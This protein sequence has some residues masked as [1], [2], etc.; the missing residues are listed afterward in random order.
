MLHRVFVVLMFSL[1]ARPGYSQTPSAVQLQ[2]RVTDDTGGALPGV[3]VETRQNA[4]TSVRTTTT[5]AGGGYIFSGLPS[6]RYDV[7]FAL[8][9][10]GAA[11]K[12]GI[13]VRAD[14]ATSVDAV[15][16]LAMTAD[17]TV[18]G[19]ASFSNLADLANPAENLVGVALA[20]SQGAI[21]AAQLENRAIMRAGE[22]LETVP[23]LIISQHSG[24]GKANQY[25]LR[26]FNLDHGTDFATSVAGVPVNMPTHA[27][28]QGYSDLNFL[29]PELVGSVQ[30]SKGPYYADQGDFSAAGSATINYTNALAQ[31]IVSVGTGQQGWDR[32]LVAVSPTI[33]RGHLLT[34]FEGNHNDGPWVHGDHYQRLNG[35]LRYSEGDAQN[36]FAV[37][38]I[39]YHGRWNSTDQVPQR[40]VDSGLI[41]RYGSIDPT[42]GAETYR[43]SLSADL[44]RSSGNAVN[45]A[46]AYVMAYGLDL[47]SDFTYFLDDP[48][49]GDQFE[50]KDARIVSG[51]RLSHRQLTKWGDHTVDSTFGVQLRHDAIGTVGLFKTEARRQLSTVRDDSVGQTSG[52]VYAQSEIQM[53]AKLRTQAG[54]RADI[55]HFRVNSS[56]PANSGTE[57]QGIVSPKGGLVIGPWAGTEFYANAA[58]GFHSNDARGA[59]ITEDPVTLKPADR[60]TPLVR[61]TGAEIGMRT[62]AIPHVQTTVTAWTLDLASELVFAGDAGTTQAGRPS[63]RVGLEWANYVSP[64]RWLT[65]D[66]DLAFSNARFTDVDPVG[67]HIPGAAGAIISAGASVQDARGLFGDL[68]LRYFG[69]RT[70]IEDNS[71]RSRPSS[72]VNAQAGYR[73]SNGWRLACEVFNLFNSHA[74]DI[75]YYYVSRLPGEP[76]DGVLDIHTH[77]VTQRMAR[78]ALRFGF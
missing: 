15:L 46:M 34:A 31:P 61:A 18:T 36:G 19:K 17:V 2:G 43:Y 65:L 3:N 4:S 63:R 55:Y 48:V 5:D 78:I 13:D 39:G 69:P 73:L 62:V 35:V 44:Q 40:A 72:I 11:A 20:S 1:I 28:G 16:H 9:N 24:E 29:I 14:R 59:T 26:G 30:Y 21:V 41:S 25:Y 67:D 45:R 50:Q 76:L 33:G 22:V 6:G 66:A 74:S 58:L 70:L 56:D 49:H 57:T 71:V 8:I 47:F 32:V 23:G 7:T 77:P 10:F 42:D 53:T 64:R 75:D 27:H 38:A 54:L 52:A 68:R 12:R 37:T 60:V 51:L